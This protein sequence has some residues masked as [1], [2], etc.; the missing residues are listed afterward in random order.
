MQHLKHWLERPTFGSGAEWQPFTF[1]RE[2]LPLRKKPHWI[3]FHRQQR[4]L[5]TLLRRI[6]WSILPAEQSHLKV[7]FKYS[8][9]SGATNVRKLQ[10]HYF[11]QL[12]DWYHDVTNSS[13]VPW[14]SCPFNMVQ[15]SGVGD[16]FAECQTSANWRELSSDHAQTPMQLLGLIT[17]TVDKF[18]LRMFQSW[19]VCQCRIGKNLLLPDLGIQILL[20]LV[21]GREL[22]ILKYISKGSSGWAPN[23]ATLSINLRPGSHNWYQQ[24]L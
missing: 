6:A 1:Y 9:Q 5:V 17:I 15:S 16:A 24:T 18:H 7:K 4:R 11:K 14:A 10:R 21:D 23:S 3:T 2:R 22:E 19:K 13:W 20:I 12:W 8:V